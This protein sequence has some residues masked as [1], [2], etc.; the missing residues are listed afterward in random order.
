MRLEQLLVV[1]AALY[2]LWPESFKRLARSARDIQDGV[3]LAA[4][5]CLGD[6]RALSLMSLWQL[7]GV[8]FLFTDA[9][10]SCLDMQE[11]LGRY[12]LESGTLT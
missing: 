7:D 6:S 4:C 10:G 12:D 3:S 11:K 1:D 2:S 9:F 5:R 8:K